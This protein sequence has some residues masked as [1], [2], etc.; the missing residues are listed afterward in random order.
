MTKQFD[1][2]PSGTYAAVRWTADGKGL[3]H[4]SAQRDRANIWLQPLDGG[5]P[6]RVTRFG[7]QIVMAFDRSADGTK[8]YIARGAL[9]RDAVL[10]K[11]F[12]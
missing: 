4:N 8:L 2:V 1:V 12:H 11:N 5:P 6:T 10:I 9:S 3:L 7:D